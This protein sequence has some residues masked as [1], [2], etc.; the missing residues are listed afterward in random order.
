VRVSGGVGRARERAELCE[1]RRG[2]ECGRW[3]G[4]KKGA[5]H[6]GGR[7]GQEIRRRARVRTRRSM[8]GAGWADLTGRV[9]GAE[10][11]ERGARGNGSATGELVPRGRGRRGTHSGEATS[12][13]RSASAGRG[14]ERKRLL[15]FSGLSL[16]FYISFL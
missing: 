9:H 5:G 15:Y 4:S 13:D 2:S 7:R 14:R 3:R 6:V 16:A 8:T 12:A 10:R 1:M 11:E